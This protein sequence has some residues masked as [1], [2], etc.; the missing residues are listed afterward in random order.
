MQ[1][2]EPLCRRVAPGVLRQLR[3]VRLD[4][5]PHQGGHG[6]RRP[7]A[8][9]LWSAEVLQPEEA[10]LGQAHQQDAAQVGPLRKL[11]ALATPGAPDHTRLDALSPSQRERDEHRTLRS[12]TFSRRRKHRAIE[13][14]PKTQCASLGF[15]VRAPLVQEG[16]RF[17]PAER[18]QAWWEGPGGT[19]RQCLSGVIAVASLAGLPLRAQTRRNRRCLASLAVIA[20]ACIHLA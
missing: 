14:R 15:T 10:A 13:R 2:P 17:Q 11:R 20:L 8:P 9:A 19:E 5:G 4:Y 6:R 16:H 7:Q 18:P 1:V 12:P 3:P